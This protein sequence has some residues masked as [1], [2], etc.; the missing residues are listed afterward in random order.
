MHSEGR[1]GFVRLSADGSRLAFLTG[2]GGVRD[3]GEKR[4]AFISASDDRVRVQP[5]VQGA[6]ASRLQMFATLRQSDFA[7][8]PDGRHVAFPAIDASRYYRL[9]VYVADAETGSVERWTD[10]STWKFSVAW[11]PDGRHLAVGTGE[12]VS[13]GSKTATIL[14]VDSPGVAH[15]IIR[16]RGRLLT[17]LLWSP[18]GA[19]LV[20]GRPND[21]GSPLVA[22]I[23]ADGSAS[24]ENVTLP[25]LKFV[26]FTPDS[27]LLFARQAEGM[28]SHLVLVDRQSG[29]ISTL[30]GG[31]LR[32]S[33][34]GIG[35]SPRSAVVVLT[36]ESGAFP[37]EVR[38]ARLAPRGV[39]L[40]GMRV[41]AHSSGSIAG[42]VPFSFSVFR[43]TSAKGDRL[44]AKLYLPR[45]RAPGSTPPLIVVPY[46][47]YGNEF[48][49]PNYFLE[50]GL[51][52]LLRRGWAVVFPNTRCLASDET[53]V[54]HYG[55]VQ[56]EDTER[57]IEALG[58]SRLADPRRTAVIGHS[59]GGSLAYY[60]ASHFAHFC[61]VIAVNGRADWEAQARIGD[62]SLI[63]QMGGVPEKAPEFFAKTLGEEPKIVPE[64]Y[65]LFSPL[66]NV[67]AVTTPVLAV[68]GK[69]DIQILPSNASAI[70]SALLAAHKRAQLLEFPD[71]GHLIVKPE[72]IHRLWEVVFAWLDDSCSATRAN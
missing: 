16:V 14:L 35:G 13:T 58:A 29:R 11:S 56:L 67:A 42:G 36:A 10:D 50:Q 1:T 25:R 51:L 68:A 8:S 64:L 15:E 28:S 24:I 27:S 69:L 59:H 40:L 55:D 19:W 34:I 21:S 17:D 18:N 22:H 6:M 3:E 38:V 2:H 63:G 31:D 37:R 54:G 44:E 60:Y 71:E 9:E 66:R 39:G 61:S 30:T 5:L 32:F 52:E 65:A 26:A 57:M 48:D 53:C 72:N 41:V 70:T 4:V 7:W 43:W 49:D 62:F 12:S 33:A 45:Q 20:A 46:G 23:A 47:G